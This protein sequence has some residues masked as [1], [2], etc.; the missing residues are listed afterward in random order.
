MRATSPSHPSVAGGWREFL[1]WPPLPSLLLFLIA[2]GLDSALSPRVLTTN[3]LVGFTS[4]NLGLVIASLGQ[5]I[6][7]IGGVID[8][9][10]GATISLVNVSAVGLFEAGYGSVA[11]IGLAILVGVGIG[12]LNGIIVVH[13][14]ISPLLATFS[15]SF[16][17][18]GIALW[19]RPAPSG[20]IPIDFVTWMAGQHFGIPTALLLMVAAAVFLVVIGRTVFMLHLYAV[21]GSAAKSYFSGVPVRKIKTI[22][23]L[24][25]G[26][27]TGLAGIAVTF[28]VGSADPLIGDSYVLQTIGAPVIGGVAILGGSGDPIGAIF[29]ALFLVVTSEL[30]LGFGVSPFYQQFVVG[31][32]ILVGLGG[33]VV[34][35][36]VLRH[37]RAR[38]AVALRRYILEMAP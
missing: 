24:L 12:L 4:T 36:R 9:S 5:A 7:L 11:A 17:A 31:I 2:F 10:I 18:G 28:S 33:V 15:S 22:A 27:L 19:L 32:I 23:Y 38:R 16:V 26:L 29:G 6:L 1:L 25:S 14:R 37:W 30:L 21:G 13:I 35:Q 3:G 20:A 8:L 34:L